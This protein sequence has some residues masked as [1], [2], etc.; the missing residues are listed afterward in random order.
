MELSLAILSSILSWT[1]VPWRYIDQSLPICGYAQSVN[2]HMC[3]A[4]GYKQGTQMFQLLKMPVY[5][6]MGDGISRH[7]VL[8]VGIPVHF[9]PQNFSITSS[10]P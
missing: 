9:F 5:S 8:H 7:H 10:Q 6:N 2:T 4:Q 1:G 3:K